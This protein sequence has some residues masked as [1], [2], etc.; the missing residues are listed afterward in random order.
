MRSNQLIGTWSLVSFSAKSA[1]GETQEPFGPNPLGRL[2]YTADGQMSVVL[3]RTGRAKFASTDTF[4]GSPNEIK[5]AFEGMEAYAGTYEINEA[6]S[7]VTHHTLV[8]RIPN[9]EGSMQKRYFHVVGNHL[10]LTSPPI[11]AKGAE[12]V[13]TIR[14]RRCN[15]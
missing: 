15:N 5:E 11:F 12:W 14:W 4:A 7:S 1:N 2:M 6:D 9:W 13:A 10:E 8:A 3:T